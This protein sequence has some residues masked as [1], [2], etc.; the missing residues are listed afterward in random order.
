[1]KYEYT[2]THIVVLMAAA[3]EKEGEKIYSRSL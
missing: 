2:Q 3:A 1:M